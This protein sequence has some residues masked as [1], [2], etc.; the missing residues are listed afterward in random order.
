LFNKNNS[1][2]QL[3]NISHHLWS[4]RGLHLILTQNPCH[5]CKGPNTGHEL[6]LLFGNPA[7]WQ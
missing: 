4:G 1:L 2:S 5:S 7:F 3:A 6:I